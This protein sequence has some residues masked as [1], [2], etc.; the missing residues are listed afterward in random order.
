MKVLAIHILRPGDAGS[1]P[2]ILCS[3]YE[4]SDFSFLTKG[5]VQETLAFLSK[6]C[7]KRTQPGTRHSI[8]EKGHFLHTYFRFDQLCAVLAT[9]GEYPQNAAFCFLSKAMDDFAAQHGTAWQRPATPLRDNCM[10]F[11]PLQ[12]MIVRY[13]NPMEADRLMSVRS[14]LEETKVVLHKTIEELLARGERLEDL[15][16]TSDSLSRNSKMFYRTARSANSCCL[17]L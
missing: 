3:A 4:L 11:P 7:C 6:F 9:D 12:Q 13:Q 10:P 1:D 2:T 16:E 14:H 17:V 15:V 8:N 5:S